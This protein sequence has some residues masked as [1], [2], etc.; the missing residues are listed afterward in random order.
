MEKEQ[1]ILLICWIVVG[2]IAAFGIGFYCGLNVIKKE[3]EEIKRDLKAKQ[4]KSRFEKSIG[5]VLHG[6]VDKNDSE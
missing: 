1:L 3:L 6:D 2:V 5:R 4:F